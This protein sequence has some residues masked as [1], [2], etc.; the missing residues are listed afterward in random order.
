M[1]AV[2]NHAQIPVFAEVDVLVVGA[3]TA[4]CCAA[5]AAREYGERSVMLIERYGFLG[6]TS[7]QILDT[8]YGFY[9]PGECPRK[10]VGG[11]PYG[12][13]FIHS[14][15]KPGAPTPCLRRIA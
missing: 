10:V 12:R 9:T 5:L 7:T 8:F 3:G 11:V 4:G 15:A 13:A 1:Q 14:H 2:F 6:G